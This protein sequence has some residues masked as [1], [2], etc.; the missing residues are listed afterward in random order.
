[1]TL[2][3]EKI[4]LPG[5]VEPDGL[6]LASTTLREPAPG[7]ALVRVD[8][9]GVS[10]AEQ[11]MRR[12]KY[13]DQP[14]FP[15][16]PGY[17]LVGTVLSVTSKQRKHLVGQRVAAIT[18]T[19]GW[20]THTLVD[21]RA[22]VAV[23][24]ALDSGEAETLVVNGLTA[25][26]MLHRTAKVKDGATVVVFGANGGV[27]TILTQLA[28]ASGMRV[29]AT[30]SPKHHNALRDVGA[31][32]LDYNN[33]D[34][35]GAVLALATGGVDAVFDQVGGDGIRSSFRMLGR[36][37]T[38]VSYGSASTKNA[39]GSSTLPVLA[40]VARLAL[41][42]ILPNGRSA[43]FYNLWA[44]V[45]RQET[46]YRR[47]RNDLA[48]VFILATSGEIRGHVAARFPLHQAAD[49]LR[50]AESRTIVGKVIIEP[51]LS[52]PTPE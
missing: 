41:W 20:A 50:L 19:G 29:I 48:Q 13:Y 18:K 42:N 22:L 47:V 35:L 28:L 51:T 17:D 21:E 40:L 33:P 12:G 10:F 43:H 34:L 37:G 46:Y 45:K 31:E 44:G 26:Q 49:A 7:E 4:V 3:I 11:Q 24:D 8:A 38:L 23:P 15:F 9:T 27:G 52:T 32:P 14:P 30:A 1:M 6:E 36:G 2:T 5:I 25:W 16:V 39:A